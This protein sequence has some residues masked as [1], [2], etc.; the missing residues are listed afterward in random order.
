[1]FETTTNELIEQL[2]STFSNLY[3]GVKN[4]YNYGRWQFNSLLAHSSK[5]K[6]V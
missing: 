5:W 4:V 3:Y 6:T 1:M 2:L